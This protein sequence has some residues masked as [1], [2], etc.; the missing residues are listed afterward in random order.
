MKQAEKN[1]REAVKDAIDAAKRGDTM[2]RTGFTHMI[3][4]RLAILESQYKKK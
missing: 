4:R 3:S 1:V 2:V